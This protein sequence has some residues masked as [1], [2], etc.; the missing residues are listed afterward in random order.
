M[1]TRCLRCWRNKLHL[2]QLTRRQRA[3]VR[4]RA[5]GGSGGKAGQGRQTPHR[6]GEATG[7][8]SGRHLGK[9]SNGK[10]SDGKG[11][12]GKDSDGKGSNGKDSDGKPQLSEIGRPRTNGIPSTLFFGP[13]DQWGI[14]DKPFGGVPPPG[15]P[16][17]FGT[18]YSAGR[19]RP[20]V[21]ASPRDEPAARK[22][23]KLP[24]QDHEH[25]GVGR[26]VRPMV[27]H[28]GRGRQS[29]TLPPH[30]RLLSRDARPVLPPSV[31]PGFEMPAT[32]DRRLG[33][34]VQHI[35]HDPKY[36]EYMGYGTA[37][38]GAG[39]DGPWAIPRQCGAGS[40]GPMVGGGPTA[41]PL[42]SPQQWQV[43]SHAHANRGEHGEHPMWMPTGQPSW[44]PPHMYQYGARHG[45]PPQ[46]WPWV[47]SGGHVWNEELPGYESARLPSQMGATSSKAGGSRRRQ[48]SSG[49]KKVSV[50]DAG[51]E[52]P[53]KA[54]VTVAKHAFAKA[55]AVGADGKFKRHDSL[56]ELA[57]MALGLQ[58]NESVQ[59]KKMNALPDALDAGRTEKVPASR[60]LSEGMT[61]GDSADMHHWGG[62][63]EASDKRQGQST[64][65]PRTSAQAKEKAERELREHKQARRTGGPGLNPYGKGPAR[66]GAGSRQTSSASSDNLTSERIP[67]ENIISTVGPQKGR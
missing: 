54:G 22:P 33:E 8:G 47:A 10:G 41:A 64:G 14:W 4:A 32:P 23:G 60:S 59:A 37:L 26:P 44:M 6:D 15:P 45:R 30:E 5:D 31:H 3:L 58:K 50:K 1:A 53:E 21:G 52:G 17:G 51:E 55:G 42:P 43:P 49:K 7:G 57:D 61:E 18:E 65:H 46:S 29:P 48:A 28:P 27:Y 25:V 40:P 24:A 62:N 39:W 19:G 34:P 36:S 38:H 66:R 67:A 20:P 35:M 56:E 13:P 2:T 11:S 12:D 16:G 63:L 9:G